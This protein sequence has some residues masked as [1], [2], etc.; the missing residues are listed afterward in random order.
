MPSGTPCVYCSV[1]GTVLYRDELGMPVPT[2]IRS[3]ST[4]KVFNLIWDMDGIYLSNS[5]QTIR[6]C[7]RTVTAQNKS[8]TVDFD[9]RHLLLGGISLV[10]AWEEAVRE[11]EEERERGRTLGWCCPLTAWRRL[12][13]FTAFFAE[14]RRC[15]RPSSLLNAVDE[16]NLG[17]TSPSN[18]EATTSSPRS[19]PRLSRR[20]EEEALATLL[21]EDPHQRLG[22]QGA[23]EAAF[24]PSSDGALDTSYFTSRYSWNPSDEQIFEASEFEDSS[25]NESINPIRTLF[26]FTLIPMLTNSYP[27]TSSCAAN[28]PI[29]SVKF[30][31]SK[32]RV[33]AIAEVFGGAFCH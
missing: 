26:F 8:V 29:F 14:G 16:E 11:K 6:G 21:T 3:V 20:G 24:V 27:T 10:A 9:H 19:Y 18:G 15:L 1:L 23:P 31:G 30:T 4:N 2:G 13:F 22:A 32:L 33:V 25:D 17:T 7:F 28:S 5:I 12:G